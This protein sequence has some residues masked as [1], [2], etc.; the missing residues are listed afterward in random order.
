MTA[1]SPEYQIANDRDIFIPVKVCHTAGTM[2][3]RKHNGFIFIGQTQDNDIEEASYDGSKAG[4]DNSYKEY[5]V[6]RMVCIGEFI[7][8]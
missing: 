8:N 6:H 7:E 4:G 3:G 1:F 5:S 2:R